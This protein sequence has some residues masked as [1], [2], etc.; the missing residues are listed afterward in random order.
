[1][2]R[3]RFCS[4]VDSNSHRSH[5][6]LLLCHLKGSLHS[7]GCHL[8]GFTRSR[9]VALVGF[10]PNRLRIIMSAKI[11]CDDIRSLDFGMDG[12]L[13]W[14]K[15][16][17]FVSHKGDI[18]IFHQ[19]RRKTAMKRPRFPCTSGFFYGW[20]FLPTIFRFGLSSKISS[21]DFTI[22]MLAA[23]GTFVLMSLI[24]QWTTI[25][26]YWSSDRF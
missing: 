19:L 8:N 18:W 22:D 10:S 23:L 14:R 20:Y 6:C 16:K 12:V 11:S 1:M 21:N 25:A 15:M 2:P 4:D 13:Q 9:L 26:L 5:G 17:F 3:Q 7:C 24:P